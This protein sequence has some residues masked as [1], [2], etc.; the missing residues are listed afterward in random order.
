MVA[1]QNL[2]QDLE[3]NPLHAGSVRTFKVLG[4]AG[5]P[6]SHSEKYAENIKA[7]DHSL[8]AFFVHKTYMVPPE[9]N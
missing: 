1:V 5:N 7:L 9:A 6:D 4:W 2:A 3:D 8:G